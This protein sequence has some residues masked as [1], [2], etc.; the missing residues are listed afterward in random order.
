MNLRQ[1][2][3][4]KSQFLFIVV[5]VFTSCNHDTTVK[6]GDWIVG[7]EENQIRIIEKQFRGFD[8]TMVET[9][10]RYQELY[11]AGKDKNW[12]YA[13]YQVEKIRKTINNGLERRPKRGESAQH[14]LEITIPEMEKAIQS[15]DSLVFDKSFDIFTNA[16]NNC[17]AMEQ[18][19]FFNVQTPLIRQSPIK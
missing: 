3:H 17:H 13:Q 9:G 19:S 11:W 1:K 5:A 2:K 7:S 6:Q 12:E 10:Y 16:C 18:V 15:K 4:I 14:F 8:M